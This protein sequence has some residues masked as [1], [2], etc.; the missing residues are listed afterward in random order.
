[1]PYVN[2]GQTSWLLDL[3]PWVVGAHVIPKGIIIGLL[4]YAEQ[5]CY[6][7]ILTIFISRLWGKKGMGGGLVAFQSFWSFKM[8]TRTFNFR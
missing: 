8:G 3:S 6:L 7:N 1:M 4:Y 2:N 5:N